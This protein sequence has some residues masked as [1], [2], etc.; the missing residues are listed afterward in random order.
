[1]LLF[2]LNE[3]FIQNSISDGFFT[4]NRIRIGSG[5]DHILKPDPDPQPLAEREKE[6][7][8]AGKKIHSTVEGQD[9]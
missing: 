8:Q 5:S 4:E 9:Y 7:V 2:R 6:S 1:M 3:F